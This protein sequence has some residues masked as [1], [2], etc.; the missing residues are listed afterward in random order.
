MH[1]PALLQVN[2]ASVV[3]C[4]LPSGSRP[5]RSSGSAPLERVG[6]NELSCIP[7]AEASLVPPVSNSRALTEGTGAQERSCPDYLRPVQEQRARGYDLAQLYPHCRNHHQRRRLLFA[8][9]HS[10]RKRTKPPHQRRGSVREPIKSGETLGTAPM[11]M[12]VAI[13]Y[14]A[15]LAI[16]LELMHRARFDPFEL[17]QAEP[18]ER[19]PG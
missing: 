12:W 5:A 16:L 11:W 13:H 3:V 14:L 17:E 7:H 10:D 4:T 8:R 1:P 18:M 9:R 15:C 6:S 2:R 19:E